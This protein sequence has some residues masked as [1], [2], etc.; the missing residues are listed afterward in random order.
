VAGAPAGSV[1]CVHAVP[2]VTAIVVVKTV[3][4]AEL[5][6][7]TLIGITKSYNAFALQVEHATRAAGATVHSRSVSRSILR[8]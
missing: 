4:T 8:I 5:A 2:D 7:A 3:V 6:Y 1:S